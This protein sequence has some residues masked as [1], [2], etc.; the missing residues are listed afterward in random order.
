QA[1]VYYSRDYYLAGGYWKKHGSRLEP[2][3]I[4]KNNICVANS[5]FLTDYCRKYN[6]NSYYV[7]QGCELDLFKRDASF[8]MPPDIK[9]LKKPL[10]GYAGEIGRAHVCTPVT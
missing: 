2:Q 4:G 7:G 3:L 9:H 8:D 6:E 10:I 5:V 1:S